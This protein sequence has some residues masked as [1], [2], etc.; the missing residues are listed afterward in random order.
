LY[1]TTPNP[2]LKYLGQQH[3]LL[4]FRRVLLAF[5]AKVNVF[6][7]LKQNQELYLYF[8]FLIKIML[9]VFGKMQK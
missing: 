1:L 3:L 9:P 4:A 2:L 5:M 6:G 7:A 8:H